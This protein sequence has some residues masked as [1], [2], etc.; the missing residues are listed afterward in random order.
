MPR[1]SLR[2]NNDRQ[3]KKAREEHKKKYNSLL[4]KISEKNKIKK[5]IGYKAGKHKQHQESGTQEDEEEEKPKKFQ[6]IHSLNK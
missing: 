3:K 5:N 1:I 6:F 4:Q 2:K